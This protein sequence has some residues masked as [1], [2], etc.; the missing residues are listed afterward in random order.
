MTDKMRYF[1]C[2]EDEWLVGQAPFDNATRGLYFT[3]CLLMYSHGGPVEIAEVRRNCHDHGNA[4]KRQLDALVAAGKLLVNGPNIFNKRVGNELKKASKRSTNGAEN[5]G[6]R[7]KNNG[8]ADE[9][10]IPP[11]NANQ[12]YNQ[13]QNQRD[14]RET[15]SAFATFWLAYPHKVGKGA[16]ERAFKVA[17]RHASLD[18]LLAGVRRY[19][20]TKPD[21]RNWCNP[22]TWLNQRR[23][24]DELNL[25]G[26][27]SE[28]HLT[29]DERRSS[30][31]EAKR[32]AGIR[33]A[34][35]C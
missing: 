14:A 21:D 31:L 2:Y 10:V 30:L 19:I 7:W 33:V 9:P 24:E 4:F 15:R 23:W 25:G 35:D 5:V 13:N 34:D 26:G 17:M 6:K 18:E 27:G 20:A 11:S 29:D 22:S 32:R 12:N 1:P 16:A 28:E 3:A 8:V